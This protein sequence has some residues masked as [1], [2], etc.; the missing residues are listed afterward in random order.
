MPLGLLAP[1]IPAIGGLLGGIFG[2]RKPKKSP[3]EQRA[4]QNLLG[5]SDQQMAAMNQGMG[6]GQNTLMPASQNM[7]SSFSQFLPHALSGMEMASGQAP[8]S[9][10]MINRSGG[11]AGQYGEDFLGKSSAA[12]QPAMDYWSKLLS[13]EG[14]AAASALAPEIRRIGAGYDQTKRNLSQF[15]PSGGGRSA[16]LGELPF[17]RNADINNLFSSL[18]PV[19]AQNMANIGSQT[20]Q[21][22]SGLT[23]FLGSMGTNLFNNFS[24]IAAGLGQSAGQFGTSLGSNLFSNLLNA[25]NNAVGTNTAILGSERGRRAE[26]AQRGTLIG[27]GIHDILDTID[28]TGIGKRGTGSTSGRGGHSG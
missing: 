22:G 21:L 5:I 6:F 9:L 2:G 4:Y 10:D 7:L 3:E 17:Q 23:Q 18:R 26:G 13:G 16:T 19:A 15:A 28:W 20:G 24:N 11:L 12:F 25:G 27:G 14:G 8:L 1:A